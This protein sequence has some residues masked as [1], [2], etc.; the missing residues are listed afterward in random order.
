MSK[1]LD[2]GTEYIAARELLSRNRFKQ[3]DI[4]WKYTQISRHSVFLLR[5]KTKPSAQSMDM[6]TDVRGLRQEG[7]Y[8]LSSEET[9]CGSVTEAATLDRSSCTDEGTVQEAAGLNQNQKCNAHERKRIKNTGLE[10]MTSGSKKKRE[11][12]KKGEGRGG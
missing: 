5:Y 9:I 11:E 1:R 8:E 7:R 3:A 4:Y 12:G 2:L 10:V 6:K